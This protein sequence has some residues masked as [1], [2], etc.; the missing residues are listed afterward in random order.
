MFHKK[1]SRKFE[2]LEKTERSRI[3]R[4]LLLLEKFPFIALDIKKLRGYKNTY[5]LRVGNYRIKFVLKGD[6]L[7]FYDIEPRGKAYKR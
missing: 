5:R 2:K 1:F 4:R 3:Y 7:I 6:T